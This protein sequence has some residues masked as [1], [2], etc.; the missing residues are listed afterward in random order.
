[1]INDILL[2][3]HNQEKNSIKTKLKGTTKFVGLLLNLSKL[4]QKYAPISFGSS[5]IVSD[6][7]TPENQYHKH[8]RFTFVCNALNH[9]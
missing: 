2:K 8:S 9:A 6:K 5:V 1:M 7:N 3:I 4:R